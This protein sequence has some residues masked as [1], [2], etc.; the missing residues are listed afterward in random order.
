MTS[1]GNSLL[2]HYTP[3]ALIPPTLHIN[4]TLNSGSF[5]IL[6]SGPNGQPYEVMTSTD[7]S[8]PLSSWTPLTSGTFGDDPVAYTDTAATNSSRFYRILSTP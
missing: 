5:P 4:G 1:D 3:P 8:L 2:L 6:F 7:V